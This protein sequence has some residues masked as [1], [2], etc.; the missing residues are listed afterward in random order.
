MSPSEPDERAFVAHLTAS[1]GA[2]PPF[3]VS[4]SI[5]RR[6][7]RREQYGADERAV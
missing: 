3:R 5:A 4:S 1:S 2:E 6:I 7:V